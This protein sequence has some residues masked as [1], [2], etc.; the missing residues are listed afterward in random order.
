MRLTEVNRQLWPDAE[1]HEIQYVSGLLLSEISETNF[2]CRTLGTEKFLRPTQLG[3]IL[4]RRFFFI[5]RRLFHRAL[6]IFIACGFGFRLCGGRFCRLRVLWKWDRWQW[7]RMGF[8]F[9]KVHRHPIGLYLQLKHVE[10]IERLILIVTMSYYWA[11]S[12]GMTPPE[13][14]PVWS[15][16]KLPAA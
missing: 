1:S 15:Q 5:C 9:R 11:V 3:L 14:P 10:R 8:I 4:F 2:R 13:K 16:K 12:T 6:Q 7:D